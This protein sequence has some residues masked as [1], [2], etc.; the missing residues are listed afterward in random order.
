MPEFLRSAAISYEET[1]DGL[2]TRS[3]LPIYEDNERVKLD[4]PQGI[5]KAFGF[6]PIERSRFKRYLWKRGEFNSILS[7]KKQAL[8]NKRIADK[9]DKTLKAVLD[10]NEAIG[11]LTREYGQF[12]TTKPIDNEYIKTRSK[13]YNIKTGRKK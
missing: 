13:G 12:I 10:F 5:L 2:K 11:K 3:G 6:N 8:A 4:V 1:T 7:N 9:S